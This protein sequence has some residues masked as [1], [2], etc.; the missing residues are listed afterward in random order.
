MYESLLALNIMIECFVSKILPVKEIV[1]QLKSEIIAYLS[2]KKLIDEES[3]L[4]NQELA[5]LTKNQI[6][7]DG[8]KYLV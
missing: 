6:I 8:K 7:E 5:I 2:E 4:L 3:A 1:S